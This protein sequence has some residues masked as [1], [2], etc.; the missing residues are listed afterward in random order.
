MRSEA[1]ARYSR[2]TV[3]PAI[4]EKGQRKLLSST[5]LVVGCGALGTVSASYLARAGVGKL[6]IVD[7]DFVESH[8]LQRQIL[9]TESDVASQLPKAVA[10]ERRLKEINSSIEVEGIVDD[11]NYTNVE[12]LIAHVDVIVDG[13]DNLETRYLINDAAVKHSIPWVYGGVLSTSGI[14]MTIVPGATACFRCVFPHVPEPGSMPTCETEGV[15]AAAPAMIASLQFV[16]TVKVLIGATDQLR[17]GLTIIDVWDGSMETYEVTPAPGCPVCTGRYEFIE[18]GAGI[19]AASLC[20]QNAVQILLPGTSRLSFS[21][22]A[23]RLRIA[24]TVST[25][26]FLLRFRTGTH[27][28]VVF[29]NGRA[30][31]KGTDDE[32]IAKALYAKYIGM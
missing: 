31:V 9:F 32:K 1:L 3:L 30:I 10:A 13:V 12:R 5:V 7:R 8:N 25:N 19:K 29:Q 14:T 24:G 6:V 23:K 17:R 26:E 20:G 28:L 4:G 16:E 22:L 2:Q 21:E 18:A 11:L 15:L 27:E